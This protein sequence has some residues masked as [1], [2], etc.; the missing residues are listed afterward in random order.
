MERAQVHYELFVRRQ[1]TSGWTLELA[2]EDRA[3][4]LRTAEESL[5]EGRVAAVRVTKE[6][7]DEETR[8]FRSVTILTKG[9]VEKVKTRKPRED[10]GPLCVSPSDLYT[11]HARDRIGRLLEQWLVRQKATPFELLHRADL[12][13]KLE[14]S[15]VELQHAIQKIA[16]PE[17]QER[18]IG[19]HEIIRTFQQLAQRAIDRLIKDHRKGSLPNLEKEGFAAAAERLVGEPE[20]AYLL[21]AGVAAVMSRATSWSEKVGL[22]LDLADAAPESPQARALA[23]Q[24]IEQPLNE[25]LGSRSGLAELLGSDLD[26]G[27]QLAAMTRLAGADPVETLISVEP[28]VA[29]AMPALN[30]PA[31]RL[32]N[33]LGGPHFESCRVAIAQRVLRELVGPRRLKPSDAEGE[34]EL[35]RALAMALT[36]AGDR[37]L[38][39]DDVNNAFSTRSKMLVTSD[40]VE[41]LLGSNRG[42]REE[43]ETLVRLAEN[44]TGA[45]NKRQAA[46]WLAANISALRFEKELRSGPDSPAAKLAGLAKLQ[47][48]LARVGLIAE[49]AAPLQAKIGEVAGLIESD[50]R[51]VA[52]LA[53]ANAPVVHRLSLLLRMAVGDAAPIGPVADRARLEAL[54]MV[55]AP[56]LRAELAKS[57]EALEKVRGLMQTAGLAA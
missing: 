16:I 38:S 21:G 48:E 23:L 7:L 39:P 28:S 45:A 20:R 36:A 15:G 44:V 42:A 30:G 12:V 47:K 19:V 18:G 22:L 2:T 25:I 41:A 34:I 35:L 6:T 43:V 8:E 13:E 56:E 53:R 54:K 17:A 32:A 9:A 11:A 1:P 52:L 14:A 49:D 46:R 27:G 29:R 31:A 55:R 33:W 40:F 37:V 5:A 57:P 51:L 3:R 26:V 4:A 50:S 10:S 24:V